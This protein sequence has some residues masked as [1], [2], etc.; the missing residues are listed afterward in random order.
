MAHQLSTIQE[1]I[2]IRCLEQKFMTSQEIL[3]ELWDLPPQEQESKPDNIAKA[4]YGSAHAALSR[5]LTRLW[6]RRL[7]RI[8]KSLTRPGTGISLTADGETVIRTILGGTK[9]LQK[10]G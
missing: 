4:Q 1:I 8:W 5:S 7:V 2:L 10:N 6:R 9:N 3:K